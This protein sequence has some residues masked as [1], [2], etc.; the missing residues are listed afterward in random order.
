MEEEEENA[1]KST[2]QSAGGWRKK[3]NDHVMLTRKS[4]I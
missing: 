1:R 3:I 4:S 2:I